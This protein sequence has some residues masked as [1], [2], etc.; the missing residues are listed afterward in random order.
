MSV[1]N[2]LP[3]AWVIISG[4]LQLRATA[5]GVTPQAQNTGVSPG[6][7][8]TAS[9]NSGA[10]MS[11]TPMAAGSPMCTGAPWVSGNRDVTWTARTICSRGMGRMLTTI[12]PENMPAGRVG[13]LVMYM[14]TLLLASWWRS[15]MP[16]SD[17]A[18][19]K[20]KLQPSR[21]ETRSSRQ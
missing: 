18:A 19:S 5:C 21:N 16:E 3:G 10:S 20:E 4:G 9:P 2:I 15:G 12:G 17:M 14:G 8:S 13:M 7:I 6:R 11:R 1:M